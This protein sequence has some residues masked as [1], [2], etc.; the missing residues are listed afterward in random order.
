MKPR[1][2]R[3]LMMLIDNANQK[4]I[5]LH[6]LA[7]MFRVSERTIASDIKE[8][9]SQLC[10]NAAVTVQNKRGAGFMIS[11]AP[12]SLLLIKNRLKSATN[13]LTAI[14]R[15]QQIKIA[16][17]LNHSRTSINQLADKYHVS[18][19]SIVRDLEIIKDDLKQQHLTMK[20]DYQGTS[21]VGDEA[22]IREVLRQIIKDYQ[23][24]DQQ[25]GFFRSRLKTRLTATTYLRLQALFGSENIFKTEQVLLRFEKNAAFH[26][27]DATYSNLM[28]HILIILARNAHRRYNQ[29]YSGLP[30]PPNSKLATLF[31]LLDSQFPHIFSRDDLKYLNQHLVMSGIQS[32]IGP[33]LLV[34][35]LNRFDNGAEKFAEKLITKVSAML[36]LD[37][38]QDQELF[39]NL[40]SHCF[41][42][43]ER[44]K[45]H[46]AFANPLLDE[47]RENYASL[48]GVVLLAVAELLDQESHSQLSQQVPEAEIGYLTVHFQAS[49]EKNVKLKRVIIV[50]PEGVG[51]SRLIQNRISSTLPLIKVVDAVP[52]KNITNYDLSPIDFIISTLQFDSAV[53]VVQV[54]NFL[55]SDDINR[56]N[57]FIIDHPQ[58]I[59]KNQLGPFIRKTCLFPQQIFTTR[60]ESLAFLTR[61]LRIQGLVESDF[62]KSVFNRESIMPTEIGKGVA[63]PHGASNL[64]LDPTICV[65][66]LKHPI[67]WQ[68]KWVD[69]V[70]LLA[71]RFDNSLKNKAAINSL[72][73]L[74]N[75][76]TTM[77]R[78]HQ[79]KTAEDLYDCLTADT[80][81]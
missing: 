7:A 62:E 69:C 2:L 50:C 3:I 63:I 52:Y 77:T 20:A 11:A 80:I 23:P 56:L 13:P 58:Q 30:G 17:L 31:T 71:V 46:Q 9:K 25:T 72:Y 8:I 75:S 19:S 37:L 57:T 14:T 43:F 79:A 59:K 26:L 12:E 38:T 16:L 78:L 49:L 53:P 29:A 24:L 45:K 18:R 27:N 44:L 47:I 34:D 51:F 64:V 39:L 65:M 70:F 1:T 81:N 73:Y 42:M 4:A 61:Q 55:D 68:K 41:A 40:R 54:S 48:F 36:R 5:S 22:V 60:H 67:Q 76:E 35:F 33:D 74:I 28:T 10:V 32:S 21:I 15:R 6:D 66:T